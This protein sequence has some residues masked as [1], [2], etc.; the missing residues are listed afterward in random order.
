MKSKVVLLTNMLSP[1]RIPLFNCLLQ[2][3]DFDF[4]VVALAE[5]EGNRQW[6][7]MKELIEF[8]YQIM[9]GWHAF[10]WR[11]ELPLHLNWGVIRALRRCK[12]DII[13]TS[14]YDSLAYWQALFYAKFFRKPFILCNESTLSSTT[15]TAGVIGFLKRF[16]VRRADAYVAFGKKSREYLEAF[17]AKKDKIFTGIDTVDM[18]FFRRGLS[19]VRAMPDFNLEREHFPKLLLLFVGQLIPRKGLLMALKALAQ[20]HDSEIGLLVVGSGPQEEDLK[21]FCQHEEMNYPAASGRGIKR[22]CEQNAPRGGESNPEGLKKVYFEGF[23]QQD[24]LLKYYA[25]ADVLIL[26]S[27]E[28]VWGLV[29]NEALASGLY[30]L[31]SN[32]AGAAYD[33]IKEGWNGALFDPHNVEELAMLIRETKGR[34]EEIR[35][36]REG[37]S[38]HACRE[39]SIERSAKAF[40]D[41]IRTVMEEH[42]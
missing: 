37:I 1:Y 31:C 35:T 15:Y 19:S 6:R 4:K 32:R 13:I 29:V 3:N 12:A 14:G 2:D 22:H 34:I 10:I 21:Q 40:L 33:L 41:A 7:L 36:R 11:W 17:G 5:N 30:V 28:E 39:F 20:L 9:P 24:A 27:F 18:D 23:Q 8:D 16:I 42:T 26:P 25:L 38:H